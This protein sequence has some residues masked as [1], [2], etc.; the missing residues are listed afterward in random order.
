MVKKK[1]KS[2]LSIILLASNAKHVPSSCSPLASASQSSCCD[3]RVPAADE[4]RSL[5]VPVPQ[6]A[7]LESELMQLMKQNGIQVNNN[8][9]NSNERLSA[10]QQ[11][12]SPQRAAAPPRGRLGKPNR[13]RNCRSVL[14]GGAADRYLS[15]G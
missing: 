4:H 6:I 3:G 7:T 10:Q 12:H 15:S 1:K 5:P 8:N 11:Q 2:Y 14:L 13:S 9:S